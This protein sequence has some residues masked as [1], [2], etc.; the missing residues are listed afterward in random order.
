MSDDNFLTNVRTS[1]VGKTKAFPTN[2]CEPRLIRFSSAYSFKK[3][4]T[5]S[6]VGDCFKVRGFFIP[7][8]LIK[9]NMTVQ[10]KIGGNCINEIQIELLHLLNT[11]TDLENYIDFNYDLF[12]EDPIFVYLLQ[13]HRVEIIFTNIP[14]EIKDIDVVFDAM[15]LDQSIM[16]DG[17]RAKHLTHMKEP[18]KYKKVCNG[19]IQNILISG[20]KSNLKRVE[21]GCD[22]SKK[23]YKLLNYDERFISIYGNAVTD[24]MTC[25]N[26]NSTQQLSCHNPNWGFH[27][28]THET[29]TIDV[30]QKEPHEYEVYYLSTNTLCYE[31]GMGECRF[32]WL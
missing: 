28:Y 18:Y 14:D 9:S 8:H 3:G 26:M 16:K 27:A 20:A 5:L 4:L 23:Q 12:F 17:K 15:W 21:V 19:I 32:N 11:K 25:F 2:V 1:T 31:N 10:L 7:T 13:Y 29:V 6:D 24:K 30:E 22:V